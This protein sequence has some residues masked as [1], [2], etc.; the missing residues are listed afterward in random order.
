[1]SIQDLN[2]KGVQLFTFKTVLD[3]RGSLTVGE[4]DKEIPFAPKRYFMV[5]GVP[6]GQT[7]GEHAHRECHQFLICTT[8]SVDVLVDD[9][10][11][12]TEVILNNP[13]QGLYLPPGIWGVQHNYSEDACLLVFASHY[14]DKAD[15]ILNYKEFKLGK[16]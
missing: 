15:Y 5:Y 11:N 1:M 14:Y 12:K 7:R 6:P 8:G 2:T 16:L 13:K 3:S 10:I 4:F 9:G